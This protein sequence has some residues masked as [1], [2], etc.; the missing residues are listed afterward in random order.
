MA[1]HGPW[2]QVP[3]VPFDRS[4]PNLL[5]LCPPALTLR[6]DSAIAP[7]DKQSHHRH[8]TVS[9]TPTPPHPQRREATWNTAAYRTPCWTPCC[10]LYAFNKRFH[11]P[12]SWGASPHRILAQGLGVSSLHGCTRAPGSC[13]Y[14]WTEDGSVCD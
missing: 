2:P 14:L 3:S 1:Q 5:T 9:A 4:L 8:P 11:F 7:I 10:A 13:S 6:K 12:C